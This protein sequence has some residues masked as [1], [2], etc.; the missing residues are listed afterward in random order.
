MN[1]SVTADLIKVISIFGVV[2]I[3]G[4]YLMG[5]TSFISQ[6]LLY[7]FRF[8]VPCFIFIWTYFFEKSY[9]KKDDA[10]RKLYLK[11]RFIQ[12]FRIFLIWSSIYF[13]YLVKW[14]TLTPQK[15]ISTHFTGF[16][17]AGQYFFIILFQ[18]I[19]LF[20]FIRF[21]YSKKILRSFTVILLIFLY[22]LW[23]WGYSSVP[24]L[25]KKFSDTPFVFWLP[26]VLLGIATARGHVRRLPVVCSAAL[27][28]ILLEFHVLRHYNID[29]SPYVT[30]GVLIG[31]SL[32]CIS[33][34][35]YP[36][37]IKSFWLSKLIGFIGNN[38]MTIFVLNPMVIL[39]LALFLPQHLFKGINF[40]EL[41][42]IPFLS[43]LIVFCICLLTGEFLK[44]IRL[45]KMIN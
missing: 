6:N 1:R 35:Q 18:L 16:G 15:F 20:P 40:V 34:L 17:W 7:L 33:L 2:F 3:H 37:T 25:L 10:Q 41:V 12:L 14:D 44:K 9:A 32:F 23:G 22:I 26:Y 5:A 43:S 19:L 4:S 24:P 39:L 45:S 8:A 29:H 42:F 13:I 31:S 30:P 36:M 38:T 21:V 11:E 28:L 27:V